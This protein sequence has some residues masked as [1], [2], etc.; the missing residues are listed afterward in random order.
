MGGPHRTPQMTIHTPETLPFHLAT[1][2]MGKN[3][4]PEPKI[5]LFSIFLS[6]PTLSVSKTQIS[7]ICD[8]GGPHRTPQTAIHTPETLPFHLAT[9]FMGKNPTPEPKILI[10]SIFLSQPTPSVSKTQISIICDHGGPYRTPQTTIHTP[11]TSPFHLAT[12]F[13]GKN[14]M[15]APKIVIFSLL[16]SQPNPTVSK[17]QIS[18]IC[19]HGGPNQTTQ[20]TIHILKHRRLT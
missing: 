3:L 17:T 16:L 13:M 12:T 9:I 8:H 6:Q 7:I 18:I 19:D 10:F 1:I 11:E 2:F 20:T 4:T 14:P 5:V 15:P